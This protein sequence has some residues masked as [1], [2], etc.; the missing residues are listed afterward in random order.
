[1]VNLGVTQVFVGQRA[2]ALHG[3]LHGELA[4]PH[5]LQQAGDFVR[6]QWMPPFSSIPV[7]GGFLTSLTSP[8]GPTNIARHAYCKER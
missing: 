5:L 6:T 8:E 7:P 4:V 1:M 2:E 3:A